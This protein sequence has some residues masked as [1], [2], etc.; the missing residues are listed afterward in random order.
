MPVL[1]LWSGNTNKYRITQ[2]D[3]CL[4]IIKRIKEIISVSEELE[5]R[6][7]EELVKFESIIN[8]FDVENSIHLKSFQSA[9]ILIKGISELSKVEILDSNNQL[10]LADQQYIIKSRKL[11]TESL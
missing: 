2:I 1:H 8:V 10:S 6:C 3:F 7:L 5:K 9:S 4:Q 11:L